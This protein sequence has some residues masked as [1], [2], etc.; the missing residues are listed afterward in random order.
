[1]TRRTLHARLRDTFLVLGAVLA[2]AA[3]ARF[4]HPFLD[5]GSTDGKIVLAIYDYLRDMA[6]LIATGGV[7][8]LTNVFQQRSSFIDSLKEEWRD[9]LHAKSALW[10]FTHI[11]SPTSN[12][13]HAA[14][15]ILS[16][17]VD[18]MRT[19]YRNVGE[20]P[21]LVG[22]YPFEPLHDMRRV[23]QTLNPSKGAPATS[24]QR[25]LARDAAL[26]AFYALREVFLEELDLESPTSA[27]MIPGGRRIRKPG[28]TRAAAAWKVQQGKRQAKAVPGD[29]VIDAWLKELYDREQ[30]T[31]KS[32]RAVQ[33]A[34]TYGRAE[35]TPAQGAG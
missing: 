22:S 27:V 33:D 9:I 17:T 18:N 2:V 5:A 4:A 13:Y 24:E 11:E 30:A 6:L 23:L 26:Q 10:E 8:Y 25:K 3:T 15:N 1:M 34:R 29:P 21:Q 20:T 16:E 31:P 12:Q 35:D 7:A 32:W 28:S 14:F 19:V